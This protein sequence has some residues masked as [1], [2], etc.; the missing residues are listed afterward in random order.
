MNG[1]DTED[2]MNAYTTHELV[3]I[4]QH[5]LIADADHARLVKE[6]RL[7]S[8]GNGAPARPL[9]WLREAAGNIAAWLMTRPGAHAGSH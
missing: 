2:E 5:Q 4:H 3:R 6:A 7:A 9:I 8:R 1:T